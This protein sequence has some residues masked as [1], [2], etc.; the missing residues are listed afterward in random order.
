MIALPEDDYSRQWLH[1][2]VLTMPPW[3]GQKWISG[4]PNEVVDLPNHLVHGSFDKEFTEDRSRFLTVLGVQN[5]GLLTDKW[6]IV[7]TKPHPIRPEEFTSV[8]MLVDDASFAHLVEKKMSVYFCLS[9]I[10]LV[11]EEYRRT[12]AQKA[13]SFA[14]VA[15]SSLPEDEKSPNG[16]SADQSE[17]LAEWDPVV[18]SLA[19]STENLAVSEDRQADNNSPEVLC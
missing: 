4:K 17:D 7:N 18:E 14:A 15:A 11:S 9:S 3:S 1:S 8:S 12:E 13:Q 2:V 19:R 10:R 6:R 16:Q 5:P